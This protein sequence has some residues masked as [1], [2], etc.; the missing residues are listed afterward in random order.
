MLRSTKSREV[1]FGALPA[2]FVVSDAHLGSVEWL[3]FSKEFTRASKL[4]V[5]GMGLLAKQCQ[6]SM[7]MVKPAV[8]RH[9]EG[10]Q[11]CIWQWMYM[12]S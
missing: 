11:V 8:S 5:D 12:C 9:A 7:W 4:R 10:V 6:K 1:A 3:E 2:S